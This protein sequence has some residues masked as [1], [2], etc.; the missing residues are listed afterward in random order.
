MREKWERLIEHQQNHASQPIVQHLML[1]A[2][3]PSNHPIDGNI[4]NS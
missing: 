1:L 4:N 3:E 2:R